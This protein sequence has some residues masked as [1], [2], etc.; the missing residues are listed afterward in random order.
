MYSSKVI[1]ESRE[2]KQARPFGQY[3]DLLRIA[4]ATPSFILAYYTTGKYKSQANCQ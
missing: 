1:H 4:L 3:V 2:L